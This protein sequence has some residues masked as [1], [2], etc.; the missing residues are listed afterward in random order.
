MP[1]TGRPA[2]SF[3]QDLPPSSAPA[4]SGT[5]HEECIAWRDAVETNIGAGFPAGT[6]YV[7]AASFTTNQGLSLGPGKFLCLD[8]DFLFHLSFPNPLQG[9]FS[10][11]SGVLDI[12]GA[13]TGLT[14]HLPN[15]PFLQCKPLH[16]Q[17]AVLPSSGL[18]LTNVLNFTIAP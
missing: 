2:S 8:I 18:E 5:C 13:A 17:A 10:N 7:A 4:D 14:V 6:P 15:V 1:S 9:L 12:N 3:L 16:V 11:F